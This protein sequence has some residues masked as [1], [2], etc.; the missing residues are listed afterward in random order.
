MGGGMAERC[1]EEG[2]EEFCWGWR[3]LMLLGSE[4][5]REP[6]RREARRGAMGGGK[7]PSDLTMGETSLR[8]EKETGDRSDGR[9]F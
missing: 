3:L 9:G 6:A 5:S 2:D 8:L 7:L 1:L 4:G